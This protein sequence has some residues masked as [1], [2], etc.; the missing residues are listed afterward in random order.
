MKLGILSDTHN[1]NNGTLDVLEILKKE[2][3][4]EII[5][6]GDMTSYDT[7]SL[8]KDFVIHHVRGNNDFDML[9][10]GIAVDECQPGSTSGEL[11]TGLYDG[12]LVAALH[13]HNY[14][15]Y[16]SLIKTG[17]YAYIFHGHTHRRGADRDGDTVVVNPGAIGGAYRGKRSFCILDTITDELTFYDLE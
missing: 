13:G 8:F 9:S 2:G 17:K 3:V 12:K 16:A 1:N 6:C 11:Y 7:A 5:H 4:R 14:G 15:Q 10:I